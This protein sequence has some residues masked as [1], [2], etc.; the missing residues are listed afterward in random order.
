[1]GVVCLILAS[2]AIHVTNQWFSYITIICIVVTAIWSFIYL[3][4][5]KEAISF[6][7]NWPL[8]EMLNMCFLAIIILIASIFQISHWAGAHNVAGRWR[9]IFGGIFGVTNSVFYLI[10]TCISYVD[11]RQTHIINP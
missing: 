6:P 5:A 2:P 7:I 3:L 1:M 9:N 8:T 4:S 10:S 11:W